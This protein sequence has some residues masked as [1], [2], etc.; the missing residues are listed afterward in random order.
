[1]RAYVKEL[2]EK[3]SACAISQSAKDLLARAKQ[4]HADQVEFSKSKW[5][6]DHVLFVPAPVETADTVVG[7]IAVNI[8][9]CE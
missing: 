3:G 1:M 8:S 2:V 4:L 5:R 7:S 6:L 9:V